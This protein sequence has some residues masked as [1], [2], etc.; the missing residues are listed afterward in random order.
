MCG[1]KRYILTPTRFVSKKRK[2]ESTLA[3]IYEKWNMYYSYFKNI[4]YIIHESTNVHELLPPGYPRRAT[5]RSNLNIAPTLT[6]ERDETD[7]NQ[8]AIIE[9]SATFETLIFKREK[10]AKCHLHIKRKYFSETL[11]FKL[12]RDF[13]LS[14]V[15]VFTN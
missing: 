15:F 11:S 8:P 14:S 3:I 7:K 12:L 6:K 10:K 13:F 2:K 1:N 4:L 9:L 5:R